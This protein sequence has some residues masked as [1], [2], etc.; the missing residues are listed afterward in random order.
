MIVAGCDI[1]S[2]T[3]KAVVLEDTK[4]LW[5]AIVPVEGSPKDAA[6][7]LF[8]KLQR[9]TGIPKSEIAAVCGTGYGQK[10][11]PYATFVESEIVCHAKGVLCVDPQIRTIV[12]IGGQDA[13]V[14]R[15][16]NF[17][18]VERFV[19]NDKC[20]S[21]TGRFLEITADVLEVKLNDLAHLHKSGHKEIALSN[22]C[23]VFA[24]SEIIS[25]LNSGQE[26]GSIVKGLHKALAS[27]VASLALSIGTV[28]KIAF[29][30]GVALN[31]GM[32]EALA[33]V[34]KTELVVHQWCQI[35]GALG[36]ALVA[37]ERVENRV[38]S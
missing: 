24:E 17:G 1:G 29:T 37:R 15:I 13:K 21:G 11:I 7:E 4:L 6:M 26:I 22:Q 35:M 14:C 33:Q 32:V 2:T 31:G 3:A 5:H 30:G 8:E 19:Y 25:L 18:N 10:N 38:A 23:V 34:L 16:D 27:R 36:A 12:D 28:P 20:A 9:V